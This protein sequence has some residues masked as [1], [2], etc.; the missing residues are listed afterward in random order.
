M[1]EHDVQL[2]NQYDHGQIIIGRLFHGTKDRFE[3]KIME[4]LKLRTINEQQSISSSSLPDT[5]QYTPPSKGGSITDEDRFEQK[6]MEPLK[7]RTINEQ[8]S[9][10]S[11]SL[12]DTPQYTPPSK[13]GSITDEDRTLPTAAYN[14]KVESGKENHKVRNIKMTISRFFS[15]TYKRQIQRMLPVN[16]R[17]IL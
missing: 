5:P 12:P 10:S 17:K 8:Q 2:P 16:N 3:Q 4:P 11:S 13:G 7:L 14:F 15:G 1:D 6:I 9:I